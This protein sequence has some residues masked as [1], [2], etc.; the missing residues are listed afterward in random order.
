MTVS[1]TARLG[2]HQGPVQAGRDASQRHFT[3]NQRHFTASQRHFTASQRHF[4]ANQ[5]QSRPRCRAPGRP[6]LFSPACAQRP[7]QHGLSSDNM[8]LITSDCGTVCSLEYQMALIT[9]GCR[10]DHLELRHNVLPEYQMGLI[11]S[12][13]RHGRRPTRSSRRSLTA[14]TR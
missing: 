9:S 8:A 1:S 6:F 13:C 14:S 3:A 11:T 4:T 2:G 5:P 12:G 10:N 7:P